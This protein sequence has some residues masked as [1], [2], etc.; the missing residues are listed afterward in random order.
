MYIVYTVSGVQKPVAM[1][2]IATVGQ[3]VPLYRLFPRPLALLALFGTG[4]EHRS[5]RRYVTRLTHHTI[6][7]QHSHE[8]TPTY[9]GRCER[10]VRIRHTIPLRP[11]IVPLCRHSKT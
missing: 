8:Q 1:A 9:S 6:F 4:T 7:T 10:A 2:L 5:R 11:S 3:T